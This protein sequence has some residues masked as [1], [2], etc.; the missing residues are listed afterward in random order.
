MVCIQVSDLGVLSVGMVGLSLG[1]VMI[2]IVTNIPA[3]V[4]VVPN[5]DD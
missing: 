4:E 3:K 2:D 5:D 1:V